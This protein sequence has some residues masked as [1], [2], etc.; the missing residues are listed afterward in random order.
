M[1]YRKTTTTTRNRRPNY[2]PAPPPPAG[3]SHG[4][5]IFGYWVPLVTIGTLAVGGL[6]AWAWSER[7]DEDEYPEDKP[8]RPSNA[9]GGGVY[10]PPPGAEPTG[11]LP[12][13]RP[14]SGP[15]TV[16]AEGYGAGGAASTFYGGGA[17]TSTEQSR[18]VEQQRTDATFLGR[19]SGVIRRTPSP[20]QFFDT[21]SRQVA[22]AGAAAGAALSSIIEVESNHG[23]R[24]EEV[25]MNARREERDGF[26]D[27]ERWSEEADDR[28]RT[29]KSGKAKR[30]VAVVLSADFDPREEA[31]DADFYT[32]H[33]SILS[34]LPPHHD[35]STTEL[36]ILIYSPNLKSLPSLPSTLGDSSYSAISTPALTPGSE[37]SPSSDHFDA[38]YTQALS[39]VTHPTQI[40][41]FT[42]PQ[43]YISM[44][45]HLAPQI[46][47]VSDVLAGKEGEI[48]SE[49]KGWVGHTVLVVGDGGH[50]GLADTTDEDEGGQGKEQRWWERSAMVGLGKEMEVVDAARVGDDWGRRVRGRE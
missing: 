36:F 43:G 13:Q 10:G 47:Y 34:H 3:G 44:L 27:H 39:L 6:A 50:G 25:V 37:G 16:G 49:L 42:T 18:N 38:L 41:P 4:H 40:M 17:S 11:I 24:A 2:I 46:V 19:M 7:S 29:G 28:Q 35:P 12:H 45:R 23:D 21:A 1:P 9:S 31:D 8:Q 22:A 20:Q 26:S 33:A 5:S 15:A 32:E 30:T 48:V 14:Q